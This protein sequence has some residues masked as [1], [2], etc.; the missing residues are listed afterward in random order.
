MRVPLCPAA[1]PC[2]IHWFTPSIPINSLPLS[3]ILESCN[4]QCT[5]GK[6]AADKLFDDI[7]WCTV[8]SLKSVQGVMLSDRH[9]FELYGYDILID[10]NLKPWLIEVNA[11]PSLSAT[12]V[13][14]R[15][16]KATV[17]DDAFSIVMPGGEIPDIKSPK[18]VCWQEGR[19]FSLDVSHLS[20]VFFW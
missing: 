5:R 13:S 14:D 11:S 9:C 15:I 18:L 10:D 2:G 12:T 7:N 1:A 20:C 19:G 4:V 8:Q 3:P 6:E 17:L 16:M